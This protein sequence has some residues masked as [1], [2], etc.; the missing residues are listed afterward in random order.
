MSSVRT[1][2]L[3]IRGRVQGVFFRSNAR[4]VATRLRLSGWVHN[5]ADGTV[6]AIADGSERAVEQ[7]I[8][9]CREGPPAA[10]VDR[11]EI[12]LLEVDRP[13]AAGFEIRFCSGLDQ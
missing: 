2:H 5:R 11:V 4:T 9:W 12:E 1:V 10:R 8:D 13:I 6:E 3:C 7:F